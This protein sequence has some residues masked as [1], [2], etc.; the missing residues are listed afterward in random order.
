MPRK[1]QHWLY[2]HDA[3]A[4][5][6]RLEVPWVDR[7]LLQE[8]LGCS[9]TEAWRVLTRLGG[10]PGPGGALVLAREVF[11]ERVR[12]YSED[13][14]VGFERRRR[15]RLEAALDAL[16][17]AAAARLALRPAARRRRTHTPQPAH[18]VSG[19]GR[20]PRTARRGRLRARE[21]YGPRADV[22][23]TGTDWTECVTG[24]TRQDHR[25]L[26]FCVERDGGNVLESK[27]PRFS[28]ANTQTRPPRG[29]TPG[30]SPSARF[31]QSCR[32]PL[33]SRVAVRGRTG[34]NA[35]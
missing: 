18:R 28:H 6:E 1:P 34:L 23:G 33:T 10:E 25:P 12:A 32:R 31:P 8:V 22:S 16:N 27:L 2:L 30:G 7:A 9:Q 4:A 29:Q 35:A 17:P 21:R 24:R 3:L 19:Q 26:C 15:E 14:R 11:L 13:P 20:I 5:V